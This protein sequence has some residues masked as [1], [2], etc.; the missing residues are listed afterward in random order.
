[1]NNI[2]LI[3]NS[4]NDYLLS[5]VVRCVASNKFDDI[6]LLEEFHDKNEVRLAYGE[7][8]IL[9]RNIYEGIKNCRSVLLLKD[10]YQ[11]KDILE[12]IKKICYDCN[13]ELLVLDNPF[14]K[15]KATDME[16]SRIL[17]YDKKPVIMII[18]CGA[19]D[20]HSHVEMIINKILLSFN[21]KFIQIFEETT[22]ILFNSL[23][24]VGLHNNKFENSEDF[25]IIVETVVL[26]TKDI[27]GVHNDMTFDKIRRSNPD[28]LL[29]CCDGDF[30]IKI[31][32]LVNI[33]KYRCAAK[34]NKIV[35]S[36]FREFVQDNKNRKAIFLTLNDLKKDFIICNKLFEENIKADIISVMAMPNN[37]RVIC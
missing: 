21:V 17:D 26:D 13:N 23:L 30:D 19:V 8:V 33:I 12:N 32:E 11:R 14:I 31:N 36:C 18:S 2:L 28:Y 16:H 24:E 3:S 9:Y 5:C 35:Y 20:A 1:M 22:K 15:Y 6:A 4:Y 7:H 34:I 27:F 10:E 37:I 25:Q 29:L